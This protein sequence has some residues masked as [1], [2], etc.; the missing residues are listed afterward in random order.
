MLE[1]GA[2]MQTRKEKYR[3]YREE[4]AHKPD[5]LFPKAAPSLSEEDL[6][7]LHQADKPGFTIS[8]GELLESAARKAPKEE[9]GLSPYDAYLKRK[10]T[11]FLAKIISFFVCV[12]GLTLLYFLWVR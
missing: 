3:K 9:N 5:D 4:I 8:Y 7:L 2:E 6:Y 1:Y 10:R 12:I 11:N